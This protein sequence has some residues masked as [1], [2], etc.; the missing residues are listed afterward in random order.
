[1]ALRSMSST[2]YSK[3]EK[4]GKVMWQLWC[5]EQMSCERDFVDGAG[6][7]HYLVWASVQPTNI[8]RYRSNTYLRSH[9]IE[10]EGGLMPYSKEYNEEKYAEIEGYVSEL[11]TLS[12]DKVLSI[13][14]PTEEEAQRLRWLF[15]DYFHLMQTS[16]DY[17]TTLFGSL[18]LV[19]KRKPSLSNLISTKKEAAITKTLDN[20]I[21]E[22]IALPSPRP[23]IAELVLNESINF[24]ALSIVLR[25]LGRVMED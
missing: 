19:G 21:Q 9:K 11:V 15:Y 25:E 5:W 13:S 24:T 1:M 4:E 14:C 10:Q 7:P 16:G 18:L 8:V 20:I 17:K 12:E 2:T 6:L 23:R 22:L 3:R